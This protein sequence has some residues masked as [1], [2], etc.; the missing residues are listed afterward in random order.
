MTEGGNLRHLASPF[1]RH[2][3][4]STLAGTT[5]LARRIELPEA[6]IRWLERDLAES[7]LPS[8]VLMHHPGSEMRLDGNRWFWCCSFRDCGIFGEPSARSPTFS[9]PLTN[10]RSQAKQRR[11]R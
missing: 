10:L 3:A 4:R 8:I 9:R 1:T 2:S 6:Q 5:R 7:S 11:E